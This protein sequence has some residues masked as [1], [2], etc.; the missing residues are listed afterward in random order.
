MS[1]PVTRGTYRRSCDQCGFDRTYDTEA[2]AD[3]GLRRHS[4]E[5]HH[6]LKAKAQRAAD[7]EALVDR[8]PKPCLHKF[9]NHEHGTYACYVL[10]LCRCHPCSKSNRDYEN[11]RHRQQVYGRWT[12]WVPAEPVRAHLR[13][14]AEYGIGLKSVARLSGVSHGSLSKI[15]HGV[16]APGP[17]GRNGAGIVIREPSSRILRTNAEAIYAIKPIPA[18]LGPRESDHERTPTA[19]LHIRALVAL[20]WSM[21]ELGRRLGKKYPTNFIRA[22]Q[23][24][25]APLARI[26]VDE[27]EALYA[28]LSM[29]VPPQ[30][31]QRERYSATRARRYAQERGWLPPLALDDDH[32]PDDA[33]S[34]DLDEVAIQRRM[35]GDKTVPL[36]RPE[37]FELARRW[38]ATG[39]SM[40]EM[41]RHTGVAKPERYV[42][43][44]DLGQEAAS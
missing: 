6:R 9:A 18:N 1:R 39:R 43:L 17:A 38:A 31:N 23:S 13:T 29:T 14:L 7:R 41:Q 32:A 19:R 2:K 30:T 5:R 40:A 26:T 25:T 20:G 12:H 3:Y 22:I 42:R 37:R 8:T 10:D 27:I 15:M 35:H 36:T 24:D 34:E 33:P 21:S 44:S 28:E 11:D 4:C 16:Y